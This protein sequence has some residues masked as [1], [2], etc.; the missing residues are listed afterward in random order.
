M[1]IERRRLL[2]LAAV[3][4][5]IPIVSA[6]LSLP[7]VHI[8]RAQAA[9]TIKIVVP[10]APGGGTDTL[11]R[12]LAEQIG[13]AHG[14]AMVV[15]NRPGAGT[16]IAT[17]AVSRAPPDG[18]MLLVVGNSFLINP[19]VRKVNYQALSGFDPICYLTN[20]PSVI[21]VNDSSPFRTL[22]DLLQAAQQ[23]PGD[24]TL[25][26]GGPLTPQHMAIETLKRVANVNMTYIPFP[27]T[28]PTV[29]AVLGGHVA[30][31]LVDYPGVAEQIKAGKLRALSIASRTRMEAL[32]DV[33]TIAESG[34]KEY[35]ANT[36]FGIVAPTKTPRGTLTQLAAWFAAAL[37]A[38]QVKEKLVAQGFIPVGICGDDFGTYL[39]NQNSEVERVIREANIK[40]E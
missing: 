21:V 36:W 12:L 9:K 33:P 26:S 5:A 3:A 18:N 14:P 13:R 25:A 35:E 29:N 19:L 6:A 24:L 7:T 34:W 27:G 40:T 4:A 1:K 11:A 28:A 15:E 39:R 31:A 37:H 30:S 2:N 16:V 32:P 22:A 17:E 10:F 20:L 23:K 8:A 38:P